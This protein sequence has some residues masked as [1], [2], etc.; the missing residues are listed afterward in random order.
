M[1]DSQNKLKVGPDS[2]WEMTALAIDGWLASCESCCGFFYFNSESN[3]KIYLDSCADAGLV[4]K[5]SLLELRTDAGLDSATAREWYDQAIYISAPSFKLNLDLARQKVENTANAVYNAY[6][7]YYELLDAD[8]AAISAAYVKAIEE[9]KLRDSDIAD[10]RRD[11]KM[12]PIAEMRRILDGF[13]SRESAA[14]RARPEL[15]QLPSAVIEER[16]TDQTVEYILSA[17]GSQ[18]VNTEE[19]SDRGWELDE[20]ITRF[21]IDPFRLKEFSRE[22]NRALPEGF[23]VQL[24]LLIS[25]LCRRRYEILSNDRSQADKFVRD[26][27]DAVEQAKA[28]HSGDENYLAALSDF[29]ENLDS[30]QLPAVPFNSAVLLGSTFTSI[31]L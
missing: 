14:N 5:V 22:K 2:F 11:V 30:E 15:E 24:L 28:N 21:L 12:S 1:A 10:T 23:H 9:G 20:F 4:E 6:H 18:P 13:K 19:K 27:R 26:I 31:N 29:A 8:D 16:A 25:E 3:C 7:I 17:I